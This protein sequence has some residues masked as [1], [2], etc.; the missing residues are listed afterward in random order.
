MCDLSKSP[1]LPPSPRRTRACVRVLVRVALRA[2][3]LLLLRHVT[4]SRHECDA[5]KLCACSCAPVSSSPL[6]GPFSFPSYQLSLPAL[7]TPHTSALFNARIAFRPHRRCR[8]LGAH[9][10][11]SAQRTGERGDGSGAAVC[12]PLTSSALVYRGSVSSPACDAAGAVATCFINSLHRFASLALARCRQA[13]VHSRSVG[14]PVLALSAAPLRCPC[15][16]AVASRGQSPRRPADL[17]SP[18]SCEQHHHN[19]R[20]IGPAS[21]ELRFPA[22]AASRHLACCSRPALRTAAAAVVTARHVS[23]RTSGRR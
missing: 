20:C 14:P 15:T 1:S 23:P 2:S 19:C 10:T 9:H 5:R 7:R 3:F 11:P 21:V 17:C 6:L 22:A 18:C 4:E 13:G 16:R 12:A 8:H